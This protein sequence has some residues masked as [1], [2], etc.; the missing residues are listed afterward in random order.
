[1]DILVTPASDPASYRLTDLLGRAA[2]EIQRFSRLGYYVRPEPGSA[3]DGMPRGMFPTLDDAMAA[4]A[5]RAKGT[6][7]LGGEQHCDIAQGVHDGGE[8]EEAAEMCQP[9]AI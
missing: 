9:R 8:T 2:G 1:M 6:C 3:L 4:I 7:Q 5:G